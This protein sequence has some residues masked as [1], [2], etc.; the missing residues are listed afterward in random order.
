M[1]NDLRELEPPGD[2]QRAARGAPRLLNTSSAPAEAVRPVALIVGAGFAGINVAQGLAGAAVDILMIDRTNHHLFQ[3]LLYQTATAALAASDIASPIR[4]I[5]RKNARARVIMG[6]VT[7]IDPS[8]RV[9]TVED[10][11]EFHYDYLVLATG[12][13]Y[14]W[15]GHDEW[16][17]HA[18]VLKSL[19]DAAAIRRRLLSAF[20]LAESRAAPDEIERLLTF[21]IVGGGPTGVEL[22]GAIAELAR[23][24]RSRPHP[25]FRVSGLAD[26][27]ARPSLSAGG[28]PQS[29]RRLCELGLGVVHLWPR[30]QA[31]RG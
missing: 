19:A 17:G 22:S 27:V 1:A 18:T 9:V 6:N 2:E 26:V 28:I 11:G 5:L 12:A 3:P 30:R 8:R 23:R 15:F 10:T 25:S 31:H 14:S 7:A 16:A 29:H 4:T 13:A 21:V 20:E 24:G